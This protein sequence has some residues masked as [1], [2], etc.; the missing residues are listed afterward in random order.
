M[1]KNV[2]EIK[3][4]SFRYQEDAS[5]SLAHVDLQVREG[6]VIVLCGASG[7]GKSTLLRLINGLIPFYYHG[8]LEGEAAVF[9]LSTAKCSIYDLGTLV[10][11][12][13]QN[14]KSQFFCVDVISELAFAAENLKYEKQEIENRIQR[15]SQELA[16]EHLLDRTMFQLSGGEKQKIACA[17]VSV[18]D[19][20]IIVLDEPSANLDLYAIEEL[21]KTIQYWKQKG[22]TIVIA[23]HRLQYLQEIATRFLYMK[24]GKIIREFGYGEIQKLTPKE[25]MDMGLRCLSYD[26]L[27]VQNQKESKTFMTLRDFCFRY[28]GSKSQI[29]QLRNVTFPKQPSSQLWEKTVPENPPLSDASAVWKKRPKGSWK[30]RAK[31]TKPPKDLPLLFLSCRM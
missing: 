9:G 20:P 30:T 28:K 29:C 7:C 4:V 21:K 19:N 16:C 15:V 6:E 14:P 25:I 31:N 22:K 26:N 27:T 3:D 2:I 12:V 18:T 11:T 5:L 23:E 1:D 8:Q 24:H 17:S 10:S 13:F